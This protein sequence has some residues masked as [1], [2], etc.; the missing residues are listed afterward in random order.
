MRITALKKTKQGR[1]AIFADGEFLFSVDAQTLL[2]S[3]LTVGSQTELCELEA[4]RMEAEERY[5]KERALSLLGYKSYT[6]K[7]LI[8]RLAREGG[9]DAAD[10]VADRMEELG[11]IDDDAY[12]RRCAADLYSI[13]GYGRRR[14]EQEL[15]HR[16]IDRELAAEL[17]EELEP[18]NENVLDTLI[19]RKYARYLGDRKGVDKT[20]RSLARLGYGF[21]D[22]RAALSR[23]A[24]VELDGE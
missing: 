11:L 8:Q 17:A 18:E 1:Y 4:L 12:A 5:W 16:G 22:I 10:G 20:V 9:E 19:E 14:V 13:K 21:D 24:E 23:F 6:K 3:R 15:A 7:A 2:S